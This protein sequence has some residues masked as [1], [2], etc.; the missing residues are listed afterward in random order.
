MIECSM[1]PAALGFYSFSVS[2]KNKGWGE[3]HFSFSQRATFYTIYICLYTHTETKLSNTY[4]SDGK[5]DE[6][7]A[8]E[9]TKSK[10]KNLR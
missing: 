3:K 10:I 9:R 1:R 7:R 2:Q 4:R 5:V 8:N 6:D